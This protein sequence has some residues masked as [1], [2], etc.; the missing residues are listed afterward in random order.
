MVA[1]ALRLSTL[2][3]LRIKRV[4]GTQK[5]WRIFV[6]SRLRTRGSKP[7]H[8]AAMQRTSS[9][10]R[11]AR[12]PT[13]ARTTS[14]LASSGRGGRCDAGD[15]AKPAAGAACGVPLSSAAMRVAVQ[16]RQRGIFWRLV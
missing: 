7:P 14:L 8:T 11:S 10:C 13:T 16:E 3:A 1:L 12:A 15:A 5:R 9:A 4:L 6:V 2:R